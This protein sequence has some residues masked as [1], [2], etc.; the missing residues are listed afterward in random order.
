MK[1]FITIYKNSYGNI[2]TEVFRTLE[3]AKKE[4]INAT[5]ADCNIGP[6]EITWFELNGWDEYGDPSREIRTYE[7][8]VDGKLTFMGQSVSIEVRDI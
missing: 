2:F 8:E 7:M 5:Q 3:A 1:V 6:K 4:A